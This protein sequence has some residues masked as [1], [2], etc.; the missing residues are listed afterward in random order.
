MNIKRI[1]ALTLSSVMLLSASAFGTLAAEDGG[2]T[3]EAADVIAEQGSEG[4]YE[5][6]LSAASYPAATEAI[7]SEINGTVSG[8]EISFEITVP[9]DSAYNFGLSY[10]GIGEEEGDLVFGMKIDGEYPFDEAKNLTLFRI[11]K[12]E[13]GGNRIDGLG[14]EFAPKQVPS[15]DFYFDYVSDIDKWT[16]ENYVFSLSAGTHTVTLLSGTGEFEVEKAVFAAPEQLTAYEKPSDSSKYYTGEDIV[17]EGEDAALKTG[18]WLAAKADNSSLKVTPN[19]AY[20]TIA[21]YIGGGN[22]KSAGQT[23]TWETGE[24]K[25]GYYRLGFS[26]R[27]GT[28]IGAKV[29]RSLK[30]DGVS[31]FAEA[32]E[33]GFGYSYNW[34]QSFFA[35][36]NGDPY[37]IYIPEG[38][39]TISL[40]VVSGETTE[41]RNLLRDAVSE[42]GE[43]YVD[44]TMITGESVDT[45]RDYDL[46]AQI[47]DMQERLQAIYDMLDNSS[48]MLQE[49]TG[50]KSG[51]YI[52]I[53][54]NMKQICKL[55]IDNKYTAHRYKNEYYSKYTSLASVLYE[56]SDMPLD[57]DKLVLCSAES[58][59]PFEKAGF[60]DNLKFSVT[61]FFVSFSND[62]NNISGDGTADQ[63]LTIWVNWGTDQAQVLNS[64]IQSDFTP[65]SNI[66]VNVQIVNA[67][68]VQA[69]LS[70]KGP[71]VLLQHSRSEPVNL[72]M[73]GMLYDLNS[74]DDC[75]EVLKNFH[76]G[77]ELPYYYKDGLYALP[78]TQQFYLMFYRTDIFEELGL[79]VPE[80]WDEF[81]EVAKLLARNNLTAWLPNNTATSTAQANIGIGSINIFPTLL[82]QR[83]LDVYSADGRSTNLTDAGVVEAFSDWTDLYNKLK[84]NRTMDFYNR[85]RT[86]TCPIGINPYTLYTTLKV[87]AP[88]IAGLWNVALVPGTED[89]S[90]NINH[91]TSGGGT[92][93]SILNLT[94]NPDASWEFLKWWVS[95]TT[96][97][98]YSSE[99]ESIL[100]PIGRVSTSNVNAFKSLEWDKEM[101]DVIFT[102]LGQTKEIPEYPGSYYVSRSVYQ[103]FWNVVENKQ[104]AKKML[105]QY[106]DEADTEI[107]RKWKQYENR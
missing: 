41:V 20:N 42:L 29:Y 101:Q 69:V 76:E 30:I 37:L 61:K 8:S 14:N 3:E 100:G 45:Y 99:V 71:D 57:L 97:L 95:D 85:F 46:F 26:F 79:S 81:E 13:E 68:V 66:S 84:L 86:G 98:A 105:L 33:I 21:N 31:P 43:L 1:L 102:A 55:M 49:L 38:N 92:A 58:E 40:E 54:D 74:F 27:Q 7:T 59:E 78:D 36:D 34:Q 93:C 73:R 48:L 47:P 50:E 12:N 53:V 107:E 19:S 67:T 28:V 11:F 75:D 70:G 89:E 60:F 94:S 80:T 64:L 52:S 16:D 82:L 10:K 90:G 22:W 88:E 63:S 96:Q 25:A 62:Y 77:A 35:D 23:L 83:N 91:T 56:M 44:I 24:I 15:E 9:A 4:S 5:S 32:D 87:S 106:A 51:S 2:V 18:Y 104:N 39:H 6:Y 103:A 65:D 17:L 72:A